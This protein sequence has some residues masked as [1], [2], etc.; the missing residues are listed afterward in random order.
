MPLSLPL[1]H[2]LLPL[3]NRCFLMKYFYLVTSRKNNLRV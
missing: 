1:Q 3:L 2:Q